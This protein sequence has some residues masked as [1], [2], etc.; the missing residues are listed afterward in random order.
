MS[1]S[2]LSSSDPCRLTNC[3]CVTRGGS[4][5]CIV[6]S[7]FHRHE[8]A[9]KNLLEQVRSYYEIR[10]KCACLRP[11]RMPVLTTPCLTEH[12]VTVW[13]FDAVDKVCK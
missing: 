3:I 1:S 5:Y 11:R 6:R 10:E 8:L 9:A 13:L 2:I 12:D 7:A 4:C